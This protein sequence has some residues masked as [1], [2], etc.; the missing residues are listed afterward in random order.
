MK[1]Y[2]HGVVDLLIKL[3]QGYKNRFLAKLNA[4]DRIKYKPLNIYHIDHTIKINC[5]VRPTIDI[6]NHK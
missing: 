5:N 2:M 4:K 1:I 6:Q 3:Y